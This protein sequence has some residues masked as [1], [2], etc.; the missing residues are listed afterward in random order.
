MA[1]LYDA[2]GNYIGDDGAADPATPVAPATPS[3]FSV[4]YYRAKIVEFQTVID[5]LDSAALTVRYM[6]DEDIDPVLTAELQSR[7]A[8]YESKKGAF[9]TAA[10]ALNFAINGANALGA[11]LPTINANLNGFPLAYA[12]AIAAGV[13]GAAALIVWGREWIVG[14]QAVAL[15]LATIGAVTD[16]AKRDALAARLGELDAAARASES[17]PLANIATLVKWGAIAALAYFAWRAYAGTS[18]KK[19][20]FITGDDS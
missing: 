19:R 5:A 10:E 1:A 16:P 15:R 2:M 8:A 3:V 20:S 11:Q 12:A 17:S 6:I 18:E 13:A 7:I 4:D 14:T 9:R